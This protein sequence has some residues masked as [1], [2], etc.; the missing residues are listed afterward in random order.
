MSP[1]NK[2]IFCGHSI[3][4]LLHTLSL[5]TVKKSSRYN[6]WFVHVDNMRVIDSIKSSQ[7]SNN[8]SVLPVHSTVSSDVYFISI[9]MVLKTL[10]CYNT[11]FIFSSSNAV[12]TRSLWCYMDI[13]FLAV[14]RLQLYKNKLLFL[15]ISIS[16]RPQLISHWPIVLTTNN[17]PDQYTCACTNYVWELMTALINAILFSIT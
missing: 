13:N 11:F 7:W 15:F 12:D 16:Y 8:W 9:L 4:L 3:N 17:L 6:P 2:V 5:E 10:I 14:Y 1:E